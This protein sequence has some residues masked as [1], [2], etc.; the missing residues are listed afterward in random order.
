MVALNNLN[1]TRYDAARQA[2]AEASRVDEVKDIRD[3]A[4]AMQVY[5]KQAKDTTLIELS[6]DIRMR[7]EIKAGELLAEMAERK[8]R[9]KGGD[10]KSR[11]ATLAKLSDLGVS[12]TQSSRWQKLAALP[13]EDQ[14]AKIDVAK[15]KAEAAVEPPIAKTSDR[16]KSSKTNKPQSK[17]APLSLDVARNLYVGAAQHL[18]KQERRDE[19]IRI[20]D[21][22][23]LHITDFFQEMKLARK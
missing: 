16:P 14:E 17:V 19:I 2:L 23:G 5:A 7:A 18:S 6:T 1:L 13:K 3:K 9:H 11:P 4:V 20:M 21:G 12:K 10:P 8:E 15:R 22:L